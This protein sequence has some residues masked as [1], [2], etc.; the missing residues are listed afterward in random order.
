MSKEIPDNNKEL[1]H[2]KFQPEIMLLGILKRWK[3]MLICFI[4][5][6]FIAFLVGKYAVK[7]VYKAK[8]VLVYKPMPEFDN[9]QSINSRYSLLGLV[10]IEDNIAEVRKRLNLKATISQIASAIDVY[11][12]NKTSLMFIK[13][14]WNSAKE[15]A[16]IANSI[17]DIFMEKQIKLRKAKTEMEFDDLTKRLETV[18][19]K[20][21]DAEQ[22]LLD[23]TMKNK[24]VDLPQEAQW[25][26]EQLTSV[27]LLYEQTK[28]ERQTID[29]QSTN[30]EQIIVDL[31]ARVAKEKAQTS[32]NME[33][34]STLKARA[35]RL[36]EKI[37]DDKDFRA[38]SA[39]LAE[40]EIDMERK[41]KL[42]KKGY[43][44]KS[45][46]DEAFAE[47]QE[48]KALTI[49]SEQIKRWRAELSKVDD[50]LVPN[51]NN[52]TT[53]LGRL[54]H[55]LMLRS[56]NIQLQKVSLGAKVKSYEKV[57]KNTN[58]K[59]ERLPEIQR[60]FATLTREVTLK[61]HEKVSLEAILGKI[62]RIMRSDNSEF[63]IVSKANVPMYP[64]TK[65]RKI[66]MLLIVFWG[67]FAGLFF[68]IALELL[69][70]SIKNQKD[71]LL[72]LN[73][74]VLG[75]LPKIRPEFIA[76]PKKKI[77]EPNTIDNESSAHLE[78]FRKMIRHIR[79]AIPKKGARILVTSLTSGEGK[80]L[81]T[82]NLAACFGRQDE[83]VLLI[84][85]QVRKEKQ[86]ENPKDKLMLSD[87][88]IKEAYP[89]LGLGDYLS[90]VANDIDEFKLPTVIPGVECLPCF[91]EAI[92]PD[93]LES[94]RMKELLK[95]ASKKFSIIL[96]DSQAI[97]NSGDA[98]AL[99]KWMDG[100]IL[101]IECQK[102]GA[103]E[104]RETIDELKSYNIP[105][106]G[107]IL[108]KIKKPY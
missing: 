64:K 32:A 89:L 61:E 45:E 60:I 99:S 8:T 56:F 5:S 65:H 38:N 85:G 80:T 101:V 58:A 62:S 63:S 17:C 46:Y 93:L 59:L 31:K 39:L 4:A 74:P 9:N 87:W 82:T 103:K 91:D 48:Q 88:A 70:T 57:L 28:M 75:V 40:K 90:F 2:F 36:N 33:S 84:D 43:I 100:V 29:L 24:V 96:V 79:I 71:F 72:K 94:A 86:N 68:V 7:K 106:I 14:K 78:L 108:N 81:V 35:E 26:L 27:E 6:C 50:S 51:A 41:K 10:K 25:L 77:Y 69:D 49:D 105:Y 98:L 1:L 30:L 13:V 15:S 52:K 23:F 3:I 102:C 95:E 66:I 19:Q 92:V 54:M 67:T 22:N 44:S 11:M 76:Y 53:N 20:L 42:V 55:D 97:S 16:E 104:I 37:T 47:Y 12:P 73:E 34:I 21:K 18:N 83:R 107:I